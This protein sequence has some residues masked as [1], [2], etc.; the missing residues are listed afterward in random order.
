MLIIYKIV[1]I[2]FFFMF[3]DISLPF[4]QKSQIHILISFLH[5]FYFLLVSFVSLTFPMYEPPY[6][7]SIHH[8]CGPHAHCAFKKGK[9]MQGCAWNLFCC[10][11][12]WN[13]SGTRFI[14]P[15][16]YPNPITSLG[17]LPT[18][19][20]VDK[21]H[22][23]YVSTILWPKLRSDRYPIHAHAKWVLPSYL[24]WIDSNKLVQPGPPFQ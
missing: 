9:E 11:C 8:H 7:D 23:T 1:L 19:Y 18:G 13:Y 5:I 24:P 14:V 10:E 20:W 16:L 15:I 6:S 21:P 17:P 2:Y 22:G 3:L 4:I 12:V